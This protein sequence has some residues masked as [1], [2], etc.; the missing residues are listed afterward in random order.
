MGV[1]RGRCCK[2]KKTPRALAV[3]GPPPPKKGGK[4]LLFGQKKEDNIAKRR[5]ERACMVGG[6]SMITF[7][8]AVSISS[9]AGIFG[10]KEG[11]GMVMSQAVGSL[12]RPQDSD[13]CRAGI[14]DL[15]S[16]RECFSEVVHTMAQ[17]GIISQSEIES[18]EKEEYAPNHWQNF[19]ILD[20]SIQL[21]TKHV[22]REMSSQDDMLCRM[23]VRRMAGEQGIFATLSA[24]TIN[25][26]VFQ[27]LA[28]KGFAQQQEEARVD[29]VRTNLTRSFART[30]RQQFVPLSH[31]A[32]Q[33]LHDTMLPIALRDSE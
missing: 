22:I 18:Y 13:I 15:E 24:A 33:A 2:K 27:Q 11:I 21:P 6:P 9:S 23:A 19:S 20:R 1:P 30:A 25:F 32:A 4:R 8:L 14:K 5:L 12:P 16:I 29:S 28:C 3:Y 10:K 31:T 26:Q 17:R 7:A